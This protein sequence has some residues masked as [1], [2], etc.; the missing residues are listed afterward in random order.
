MT[1]D[2]DKLE[3][4]VAEVAEAALAQQQYV[5]AI[6]VLI[7]VG[8]L[9]PQAVDRWRQGRVEDLERVAQ[10]NLHKLSDAMAIFR[11][12]AADHGLRPRGT[13]YVARTRDRRP[14][15]FSR[16]G[17]SSIERA[18]RTHWIS[19]EL[20]EA[21]QQRLLD[22]QSQPPDLVVVS[23]LK[24]WT[25]TICSSSGDLL[26]MEGPGPLCLNCADLDHLVFLAAGD[27]ALTRRAKKASGLSAVVVRFSRT[28]GRY[29]RQGLLVEEDA[30]VQ[31]ECACLADEEVRQR[32]RLRDETRREAQ[33]L[34]F[35][36]AFANEIARLFPRCPSERADAIARHAGQRSSGRV[37]R[38]AAGRALNPEAVTLAVVASVRHLDTSYD[39]LLMSGVLRSE[40]RSRIHPDV[41]ARLDGWRG[42]AT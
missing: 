21:K 22:K 3:R 25:C 31:A 32:Q 1:N 11:R 12:W 16:S 38:T 17:D 36:T 41:Q 10:A 26:I 7:G 35:Q 15:R 14:L 18:Y 2:K 27:A 29:E 19:P 23:A 20:S 24:D 42:P 6:D 9:T 30:L 5:T 13:A 37:G 33:D 40:A 4:R 8:W 34:S 28:R 39:K